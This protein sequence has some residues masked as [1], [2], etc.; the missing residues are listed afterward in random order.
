LDAVRRVEGWGEGAVEVLSL[1]QDLPEV[2]LRDTEEKDAQGVPKKKAV[3]K[4]KG[5][6]NVTTEKPF[7]EYFAE[8]H[9]ALLPSV[10][11]VK[12]DEG[13]VLPPHGPGGGGA[14]N[15]EFDAIRSEMKETQKTVQPKDSTSVLAALGG[16]RVAAA[17]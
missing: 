8:K 2:E 12:K 11:A 14:A 6:N 9:A 3:A 13:T 1:I 10:Q 16:Q 17:T 15:N 7:A 4:V 5:A